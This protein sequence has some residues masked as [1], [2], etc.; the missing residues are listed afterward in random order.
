MPSD[1]T[2]ATLESLRDALEDEAFSDVDR[3][4]EELATG[5][6]SLRGDETALERRALATRERVDPVDDGI[7]DELTTF[8]KTS[9]ATSIGRA[10]VLWGTRQFLLDPAAGG[11]DDLS[12]QITE[13]REQEETFLDVESSVQTALDAVDV[14]LPAELAVT[15]SQ[16][17]DGPYVRG[18]A[19]ELTAAAINVG[20]EPAESV[21]VRVEAPDDVSTSPAKVGLGTLGPGEQ[22]SQQFTLMAAT[23]GEYTV[24]VVAESGD[25]GQQDSNAVSFTVL[26]PGRLSEQVLESIR[27]ARQR[28]EDSDLK[29]GRKRSL[30]SKLDSA[31][32]K[33]ERGRSELERGNRD[34]SNNQFKAAVQILGGFLNH[35]ES[36]EKAKRELDAGCVPR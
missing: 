29:R 10:G 2:V 4:L 11:G 34:K 9:S 26:D 17:S 20:D 6:D 30:Q 24:S 35:L 23:A 13:L 7:P 15:E 16:I 25:G 28:V 19:Y 31:A 5:Y 22:A 33:V 3:L 14:E 21:S 12:Q 1:A 18:Q 8:V 32:K 27:T 36:N